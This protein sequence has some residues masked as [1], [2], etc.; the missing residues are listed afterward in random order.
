MRKNDSARRSD[1][2]KR[3]SFIGIGGLALGT[4]GLSGC[5]WTPRNAGSQPQQGASSSQGGAQDGSSQSS[6]SASSAVGAGASAIAAGSAP[7]E[8]PDFTRGAWDKV[9]GFS[10][11]L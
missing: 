4:L 7:V 2:L 3:R 8:V 5:S 1:Y 9:K 11:A 10:Y 6:V